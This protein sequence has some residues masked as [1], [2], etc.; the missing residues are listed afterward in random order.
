MIATEFNIRNMREKCANDLAYFVTASISDN[1][2]KN[3]LKTNIMLCDLAI[4]YFD[5]YKMLQEAKTKN[6]GIDINLLLEKFK[7]EP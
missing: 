7:N 6:E 2:E 1:L 5:M 4:K 3:R